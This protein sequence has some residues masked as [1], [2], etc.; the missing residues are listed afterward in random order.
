MLVRRGDKVPNGV[1]RHIIPNRALYVNIPLSVLSAD[2][3]LER[4]RE[5]LHG[6]LMEQMGTNAIRYYAEPT[7][8]FGQ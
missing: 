7:F 6:W 2:W 4:K 1:T 3:T 5:W 8:L